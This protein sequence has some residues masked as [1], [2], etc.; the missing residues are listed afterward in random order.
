[1]NYDETHVLETFLANAMKHK[2][3]HTNTSITWSRIW[4]ICVISLMGHHSR[5][6]HV[7]L[8]RLHWK[9]NQVFDFLIKQF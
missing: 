8:R 4:L 3:S 5:I 1:M 7:L 9:E 6:H 2:H